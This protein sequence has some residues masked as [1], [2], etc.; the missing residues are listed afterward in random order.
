MESVKKISEPVNPICLLLLELHVHPPFLECN[1]T[2][3]MCRLNSGVFGGE[4]MGL[5]PRPSMG[6][7]KRVRGSK[8]SSTF[9]QS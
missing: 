8:K 3:C 4:G 9:A 5:F 2:N 1:V 6:N 7:I